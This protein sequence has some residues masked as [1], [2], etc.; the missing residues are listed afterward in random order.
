M[1]AFL[2]SAIFLAWRDEYRANQQLIAEKNHLGSISEE[3]DKRI[4]ELNSQVQNLIVQSKRSQDS[5]EHNKAIREHVAVFM[6]E[7]RRLR[8]RGE[9]NSTSTS[10]LSSWHGWELRVAK[11]LGC[12][13][14]NAYAEGF[15]AASI[16]GVIPF[17][18]IGSELAYL[19]KVLDNFKD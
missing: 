1:A 18:N 14:G 5:S 4:E 16:P 6:A 8:D 9:T 15:R 17:Q 19:Q 13:A 7:G 2:I 11:Y 10:F 12:H 3:K